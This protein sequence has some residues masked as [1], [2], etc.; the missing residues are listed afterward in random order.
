M[1]TL[2][3]DTNTPTDLIQPWVSFKVST[4]YPQKHHANTVS[5]KDEELYDA[6][7]ENAYGAFIHV[8]LQESFGKVAH[9][10]ACTQNN[11][12]LFHKA[13][14]VHHAWRLF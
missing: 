9:T 1:R 10:H 5:T 2:S 3:A 4:G 8:A 7:S 13:F 12:L 6:N 11:T 14:A